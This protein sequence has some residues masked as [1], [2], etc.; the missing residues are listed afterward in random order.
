LSIQDRPAAGQSSPA[1][2]PR[3][4]RAQSYKQTQSGVPSREEPCRREQT[5][6]IGW[7][8]RAGRGPAVQTNPI[9]RDALCGLSPRTC[10]GRL[11]KQ[12]QFRSVA[13][14][15]AAQTNPICPRRTSRR[16]RGWS[17]SCDNASLPGV[18]P[19]TNP[20]SPVGACTNKPNSSI[21][22]CGPRWEP[23]VTRLGIADSQGPAACRQGSRGRLYKQTQ[24]AGAKCA[25]RTQFRPARATGGPAECVKRTQFGRRV[26]TLEGKMC[27]TKPIPEEVSSVKCQVLSKTCKTNPIWP[28]GGGPGGRNAQNQ[29]N[30]TGANRAEQTQSPRRGDGAGGAIMQNKANLPDGAACGKARA[31]GDGRSCTNKANSPPPDM[32]AGSRL[33]P[34]VRNKPNLPDGAERDGP[35]ARDVGQSCETKPNLGALG[36]LGTGAGGACRA[37]QS[38]FG[39]SQSCDNA[40]LPSVVPAT[41]PIWRRPG[42]VRGTKCAKRTQF[43]DCGLGTDLRRDAGPVACR[44]RPA[45]GRIVQNEP[46]FAMRHGHPFGFALRAGFARGFESWARAPMPLFRQAGYPTI[47]IFHYS[48]IPVR[49]LLCKT[50]PISGRTERDASRQDTTKTN[51]RGVVPAGTMRVKNRGSSPPMS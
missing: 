30:P 11:Y 29:A 12:T 38:Q 21:A 2:R 24:L 49:C 44:L 15:L 48:I 20:I 36:Y 46:N 50:K 22:D 14:V 27:K 42:G 8:C 26:R 3:P 9:W 35:C 23:G 31:T 18:V 5:K 28:A 4:A 45:E 17:Q 7:W 51:C 19:A 13:P 1:C 25:K 32:Q 41:N 34:S 39:W 6:P 33:V 37:K 16:G 43:P 47:P 40:S 10:A